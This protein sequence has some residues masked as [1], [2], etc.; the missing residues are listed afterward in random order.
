MVRINRRQHER[1]VL[2]PM[3][4]R[5][6]LRLLSEDTFTREG[7]IHN[8]SEGGLMFELDDPIAPGTPVAVQIYLP[9]LHND[10]GPGRAVFALGTIV[11]VADDV[12]EPG[13]VRMAVSFSHY[14]R[15]GDRERLIRQLASGRFAR[16]A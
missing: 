2:Q 4:T 9:G 16:A 7:H 10:V 8:A 6:A 5:V 12:D 14:A 13:P 1:F 3:Y 11:W 15:E